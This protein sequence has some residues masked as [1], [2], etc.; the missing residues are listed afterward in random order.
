M[1]KS[2][3]LGESGL[4]NGS[5]ISSPHSTALPEVFQGEGNVSKGSFQ[6]LELRLASSDTTRVYCI[7]RG[8]TV[9]GYSPKC[10]AT[11]ITSV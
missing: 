5:S 2:P 10:P 3:S 11:E 8:E 9:L 1:A 4:A 7:A 6:V